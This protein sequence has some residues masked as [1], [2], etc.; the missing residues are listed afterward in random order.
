MKF[1]DDDIANT[2]IMVHS[3]DPS[4]KIHRI[5]KI[6]TAMLC[7]IVYFNLLHNSNRNRDNTAFF[8]LLSLSDLAQKE[9]D[10]LI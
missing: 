1:P 9:L 2:Q 8:V 7:K 6:R 3:V 4:R 10:H 5:K